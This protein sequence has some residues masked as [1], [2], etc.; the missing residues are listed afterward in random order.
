LL[1]NLCWLAA[2]LFK[3]TIIITVVYHQN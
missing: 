1:F 2:I 3:W